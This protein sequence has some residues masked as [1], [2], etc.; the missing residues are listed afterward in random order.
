MNLSQ[1][2]KIILSS[3]VKHHVKTGEPLGSKA[4]ADFLGV[5]SATVRNDM[6]KLSYMGLL[7]QPHTSA[8]RIPSQIGYREY[9][10]YVM[11]E[12]ELSEGEK[13]EINLAISDGSYDTHQMLSRA[14]S[15]VSDKFVALATTPGSKNS[16]IRAVQFVQISRRTAMLILISSAGTIKNRVFRCDYDLT[17]DILRI[18]F[19]IFN[20][21]FVGLKLCDITPAF[22]QKCWVSLGEISLLVTEALHCFS[23][24]V[25]DT[26]TTELVLLGQ[27]NLMFHKEFDTQSL[28]D[29]LNFLKDGKLV[30]SVLSTKSKNGIL[31]GREIGRKEFLNAG[32]IFSHYSLNPEDFGVL[33]LVG[34]IRLDYQ[35]LSSKMKYISQTVSGILKSLVREEN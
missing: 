4:I 19:R 15:L 28:H 25:L 13:L 1:R 14:M 7:E 9:I 20:E 33:A 31:I 18:F 30:N 5:S 10:D 34:P 11:N 22:I 21:K 24:V 29:M 23:D 27:T 26:M 2:E 12:Y 3:I 16:I 32:I 17:S 6:T 35:K 8:G